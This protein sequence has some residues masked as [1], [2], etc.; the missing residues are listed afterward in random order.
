MNKP[1]TVV[2]VERNKHLF[3]IGAFNVQEAIDTGS[4]ERAVILHTLRELTQLSRGNLESDYKGTAII[5]LLHEYIPYM[6]SD[7]IRENMGWLE[8][9]GYIE[10]Y[11]EV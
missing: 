7:F 1:P 4:V 11:I 2:H 8:K 10:G 5:D 3:S 9:N 6:D